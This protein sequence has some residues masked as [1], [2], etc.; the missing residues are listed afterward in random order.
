MTAAAWVKTEEDGVN[1]TGVP[2]TQADDSNIKSDSDANRDSDTDSV[3]TSERESVRESV[4]ETVD[5]AQ[6]G[7][8]ERI[9]HLRQSRPR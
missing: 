5:S 9:R 1:P 6:H 2:T 7:L 3:G 4:R 8:L